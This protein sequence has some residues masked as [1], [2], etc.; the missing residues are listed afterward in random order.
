MLKFTILSLI[1]FLASSLFDWKVSSV[2]FFK[3]NNDSAP[4][5]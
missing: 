1:F 2:S 5:F 3:E 4:D